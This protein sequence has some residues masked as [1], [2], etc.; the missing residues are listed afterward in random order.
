MQRFFFHVD[1]DEYSADKEGTLCAH[2]IEARAAAV[3]LLAEVLRDQG[4]SFWEK[5]ATSVTVTDADGLFLWK[6]ET[7]GTEAAAIAGKSKGP[8][9]DSAQ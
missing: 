2:L 1:F 3:Q 7:V 5:P 4:D 8:A 9:H 6:I